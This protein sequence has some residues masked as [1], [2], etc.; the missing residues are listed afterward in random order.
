MSAC[1][2]PAI[3]HGSAAQIN[4]SVNISTGRVNTMST[5]TTAIRG[6]N[7]ICAEIDHEHAHTLDNVMQ[8]MQDCQI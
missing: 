7:T 6:N 5:M 4:T 8:F 1:V 3:D 2:G